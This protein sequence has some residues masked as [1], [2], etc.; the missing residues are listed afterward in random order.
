[1]TEAEA[2]EFRDTSLVNEL[3]KIQNALKP[4]GYKVQ[5]INRNIGYCYSF[6]LQLCFVGS[7]VFAGDNSGDPTDGNETNIRQNPSDN[8]FTV[9]AADGII[10]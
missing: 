8:Y 3:E 6:V 2:V 1:M 4:L 10:T 5:G 9:F 7:S